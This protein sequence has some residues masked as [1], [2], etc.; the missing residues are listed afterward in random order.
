MREVISNIIIIISLIFI[1][2]GVFGLYR[3][4]N[5]YSRIAIASYIDTAGYLLLMLGVIVRSGVT[6]FSAKVILI[7][8]IV[9]LINPVVTHS[10]ARSAYH[11]GYRIENEGSHD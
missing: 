2:T 3:F 5:F 6:W 7:T 10:I 11:G 4:R 9:V 8:V 1:L